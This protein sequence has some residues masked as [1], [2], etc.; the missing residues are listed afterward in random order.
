ML[1]IGMIFSASPIVSTPVKAQAICQIK[2]T[3][4][5]LFSHPVDNLDRQIKQA[6]QSAELEGEV[7]QV[8]CTDYE[9]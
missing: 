9:L 3:E 6:M 8:L 2:Q 7:Y 1:L 4:R 5:N